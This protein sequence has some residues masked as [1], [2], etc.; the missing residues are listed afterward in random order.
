MRHID[1]VRWLTSPDDPAA[2]K[3]TESLPLTYVGIAWWGS[4]PSLPRR[5]LRGR[6]ADPPRDN[7]NGTSV[8]MYPAET[9]RG[10]S[11]WTAC[12]PS[13]VRG[14]DPPTRPYLGPGRSF[15]GYHRD[16]V[17]VAFADGSLHFLRDTIAPAVFQAL[18][19]IAGVES[20]AAGRNH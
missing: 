7:N 10:H 6:P 19:T 13:S 16:G 9:T 17:N 15:G 4:S 5:C 1:L 20:L 8:M 3:P 14:M 11:P 2:D 18:A 12:G